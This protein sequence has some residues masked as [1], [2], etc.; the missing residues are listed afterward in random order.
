MKRNGFT[1]VE[2]LAVV[3]ILAIILTIAI[4]SIT[5]IF[6][7]A[8]NNSFESSAKMVLKAIEYKK[9]ENDSFDPTTIDETNLKDLLK[10]DDANFQTLK[11]EKI[12]GK[13]HITVIG[14]NKWVGLV[15]SGTYTDIAV[16]NSNDYGSDITRPVITMLG[17]S[18]VDISQGS[19]YSDAG[20]TASD[21]TD[22]N[23]TSIIQTIST[24]NPSV[25][26]TYTVTYSVSDSAGNAATQVIRVVNVLG[27]NYIA[28]EGVN[29]PKLSTGMTPIKW[30]ETT[31]VNTTEADTTWYNYTATDKIWAN[32]K[33]DDGSMWVWI[34]RYIYKISSGWHLNTTGT[35]DIQFSKET[36]DN[37]NSGVIG[38]INI[39][40]TAESSNNA[41]TNHP[42]FTF[43]STELTGI[44]VAKF[45]ATAD[46][47]VANGYTSNNSCPI[48]GDD[49]T[50]KT[51][52]ILPN[53]TSWRCIQIGKAFTISRSMET[54]SAYGWGTTGTNI[55]THM[56]K[57]N[58][59]GAIA[60]LSKSQYG[61]NNEEIY[62]NNNKNFVTGCAGNT[63][64]V[65]SYDGCQNTYESLNG[66]KASTT[67]NI[68]GIYDLSGGAVEY[69]SAYVNNGNY[70]LNQG[71]S[72]TAASA[73][74][75]NV[76]ET[77]TTDD[78]ISNYGLTINQKG[79][80]I[81]E[82]SNNVNGAYSWFS[83]NSIMPS[84]ANLWFLR[85]GNTNQG[86]IAGVFSFATYWGGAGNSYGFRPVL[87][88]NEN[89]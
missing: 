8:S 11:I 67:G 39:G 2:L 68:Y 35:I 85:G 26:G 28:S 40:T 41:W 24:V 78:Q 62:I 38:N 42:A 19:S 89:L 72:I 64:I 3:V 18:P 52:K 5:N 37:W 1:L 12:S 70:S 43:G 10:V 74:Y 9:L 50:T 69:V 87:L 84:V 82:T 20:S 76:Y 86:S 31:W 88:V 6:N 79:E 49:V 66:V 25:V 30:D 77:G 33:T 22:G 46:E 16:E 63:A 57:N 17:V 34:P 44:W 27:A 61:K 56:I 45:E 73:Q 14:K 7:S 48:V 13:T 81:Y 4:P 23:I 80:A 29:K 75:K 60:Y 47:G 21:N 36:D 65:G 53:V 51:A 58:E 55:D 83:D 71:S 32:A 54:N 15:A 59:W